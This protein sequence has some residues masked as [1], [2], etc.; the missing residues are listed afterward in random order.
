MD[1]VAEKIKGLACSADPISAKV[2]VS[3]QLETFDRTPGLRRR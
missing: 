3:W 1:I 2:C